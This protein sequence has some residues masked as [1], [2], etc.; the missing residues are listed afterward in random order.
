MEPKFNDPEHKFLWD[1]LTNHLKEVKD[2]IRE[3]RNRDWLIAFIIIASV[4]L[5]KL[6]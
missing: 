4:V 3:L 1:Y 6:L 5:A 2:D